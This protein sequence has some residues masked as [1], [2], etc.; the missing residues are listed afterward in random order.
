MPD[1]TNYREL[2]FHLK[3]DKYLA[4]MVYS[5]QHWETKNYK[6][7]ELCINYQAKSL[8]CINTWTW[9]RY[10]REMNGCFIGCSW[11][12]WWIW[13]RSCTHQLLEKLVKN[14]ERYLQVQSKATKLDNG[15][16]TFSSTQIFW[17]WEMPPLRKSATQGSPSHSA[18]WNL[19]DLWHFETIMVHIDG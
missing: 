1:L 13:C 9:W 7:R 5:H 19:H 2:V 10:C 12:T 14:M 8:I 17:G 15:C 6:P 4:Y 3:K 18:Y 16:L 11:I